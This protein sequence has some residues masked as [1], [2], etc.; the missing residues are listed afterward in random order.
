[1][2]KLTQITKIISAL[3]ALNLLSSCGDPDITV[4][5]NEFESKIVIEGFLYPNKDINIIL[6]KNFPLNK[7]T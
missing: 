1:M 7:N 3:I 5:E 2:K 4:A 6:T